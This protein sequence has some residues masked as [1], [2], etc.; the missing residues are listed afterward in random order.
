MILPA[1][2]LHP[3]HEESSKLTHWARFYID[4]MIVPFDRKHFTVSSHAVPEGRAS[5]ACEERYHCGRVFRLW[6]KI[7]DSPWPA[8]SS[9]PCHN[10]PGALRYHLAG[11]MHS[12]RVTSVHTRRFRGYRH[13]WRVVPILW[14][15]GRSAFACALW[16]I[17]SAARHQPS[18]LACGAQVS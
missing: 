11:P 10:H 3:R 8:L 7:H 13:R 12:A 18:R 15:G 2:C 5:T 4:S 17:G 16:K 9:S 14:S 6:L 1:N